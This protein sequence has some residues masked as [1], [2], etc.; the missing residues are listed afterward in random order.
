MN[1]TGFA[2]MKTLIQTRGVRNS[3]TEKA[4]QG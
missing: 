2:E 4:E 3:A 1:L